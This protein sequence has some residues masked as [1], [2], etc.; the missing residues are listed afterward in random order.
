MRTI[1]LVIGVFVCG[2]DDPTAVDP[3]TSGLPSNV[4]CVRNTLSEACQCD[5]GGTRTLG[6]NEEVVDD[7]DEVPSGSQCCYNLD[8][9]SKTSVCACALPAC[10][11]DPDGYCSCDF[12][13]G[14]P[15]AG[16]NRDGEVEVDSCTS[17]VCCQRADACDCYVPSNTGCGNDVQVESC[18]PPTRRDC[19]RAVSPAQPD[20]RDSCAGLEWAE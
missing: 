3:S 1:I 13:A 5:I 14:D 15:V 11:V 9:E 17:T 2:C 12:F 7:C 8:S 4:T 20:T 10:Y 18:S 16:S 19:N 6:E